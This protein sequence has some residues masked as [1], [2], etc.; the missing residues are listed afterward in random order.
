M[1]E[2]IS[3]LTTRTGPNYLFP[4]ALLNRDAFT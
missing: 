2:L 3:S 1:S 4:G